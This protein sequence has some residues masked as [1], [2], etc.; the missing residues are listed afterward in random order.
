MVTRNTLIGLIAALVLV[1]AACSGG[2]RP[3]FDEAVEGDDSTTTTAAS[4]DESGGGDSGSDSTTDDTTADAT[5][6]P[7]EVPLVKMDPPPPPDTTLPPQPTAEDALAVY[8][9]VQ[10]SSPFK[11]DCA[12]KPDGDTSQ[13]LC[14]VTDGVTWT[15]GLNETDPWYVIVVS[16]VEGGWL[17]TEASTAGAPPAEG[18]PAPPAEGDPATE[19]GA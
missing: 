17:V 6:E 5:P 19:E 13:T 1:A 9:G 4:G 8:L 2:D 12:N 15:V 10:L 18:D 7:T 3:S 14:Y 16:Q 11:G